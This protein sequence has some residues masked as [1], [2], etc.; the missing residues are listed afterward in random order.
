MP[1]TSRAIGRAERLA[2][3]PGAVMAM[4]CHE[5]DER[6]NVLLDGRGTPSPEIEADLTAHAASCP[7]CRDRAAGYETLR[8]QLGAWGA[9]ES[10]P[11]SPAL[12]DRILDAWGL[13]T[14]ATD[15]RIPFRCLSMRGWSV[16]AAVLLA[17]GIGLLLRSGPTGETGVPPLGAPS[18]HNAARPLSESLATATAAT[19]DLARETSGP[20]ARLGRLMLASASNTEAAPEPAPPESAASSSAMLESVEAGLRPISGS[21]RNAFGFLLGPAAS[22]APRPS[23]LSQPDA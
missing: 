5:F 6:W 16:A 12:T 19:L 9:G 11:A 20:A 3:T 18:P 22:A 10:A 15:R 4:P 1:L 2:P 23:S 13:E 7:S 8:H 17:A 14:T 21:A